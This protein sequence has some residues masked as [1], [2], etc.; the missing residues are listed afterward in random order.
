MLLVGAAGKV[1]T[2]GRAR[3]A[4]VVNTTTKSHSSLSAHLAAYL[5]ACAL[6]LLSDGL[7]LPKRNLPPPRPLSLPWRRRRRRWWKQFP[8]S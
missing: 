1:V 8:A 4:T 3:G 7:I 2:A 6:Y 5:R